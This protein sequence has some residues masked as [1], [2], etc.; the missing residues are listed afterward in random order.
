[1]GIAGLINSTIGL[2][3]AMTEFGLRTSAVR[4]VAAANETG[5]I[6][7]VSKVVKVFRRLVWITGILGAI[8][9]LLL[10]PKLSHFTFGNNDYTL[11][12]RWVS[13]T[14]LLNQL[15][16][17]QSVL[18]QGMRRIKDL[19]RANVVGSFVGL[20]IS[21]PLYYLWGIK[22]IVPAI[23]ATSVMG[24]LIARYFASKIRIEKVQVERQEAI[25]EG[26][27]M[28]EVGFM[29]SLSGLITMATS[30]FLRVFI[31][32]QGGVTDVGF[33]NAG[34]SIIN[35]YVG[36]IFT[37]MAADYYPRLSGVAHENKKATLLINQQAEVAIIILAP[38]LSLFFL[39]INFAVIL[40][41]SSEF[42]PING[43]IHWAAMGMYFKAVSWSIGFIFLA[44]GASRVY[45][46]SEVIAYSYLLLLNMLGYKY[47]GLDGLGMSFLMGYVLYL[48]QVYLISRFKYDF[49]FNSGFLKIFILQLI[50]G[51]LCFLIIRFVPVPWAYIAGVPVLLLSTLY[52]LRELDQRLN[53]KVV[54]MKRFNDFKWW[55]K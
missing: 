2:V 47:F 10:A 37:A 29:L 52:S 48:L 6:I 16:S 11:A 43:M 21:V 33:Y 35:T 30:Y 28:L 18:M 15:A 42:S 40:L 41:Y 54:I 23:V 9:T 34:Y 24:F 26:R 45:L 25:L 38:I 39:F 44:K 17:G 46:W 22:G 4:N 12:F 27:G 32:R 8:V 31:S 7:R 55:A 19:A 50:L 51:L 13:I 1:M 53:L 3:S 14:L 20:L 49:A 5:D 36:L